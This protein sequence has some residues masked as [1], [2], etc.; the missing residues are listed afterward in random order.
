MID[1]DTTAGRKKAQDIALTAAREA[2][3]IVLPG[4]GKHP[5][6]RHKGMSIWS[7]TTTSRRALPPK[8]AHRRDGPSPS[9]ARKRAGSAPP[10]LAA[11]PG[12]ST[13]RRNHELRPR[14]P[15]F[16]CISIGSSSGR[17]PSWA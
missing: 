14:P 5:T 9:W 17:G 6:A 15:F 12:S 13:A 4:W 2:A 1:L 8:D 7:P 3:K 10:G 11:R 16:F